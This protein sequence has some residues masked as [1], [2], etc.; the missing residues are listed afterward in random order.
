M[1]NFLR[2]DAQCHFHTPGLRLLQGRN[3]FETKEKDTT[4]MIIKQSFFPTDNWNMTILSG[5]SYLI[6]VGQP[7]LGLFPKS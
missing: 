6:W 1:Q 2:L 7:L 5:T 4:Q 3:Q